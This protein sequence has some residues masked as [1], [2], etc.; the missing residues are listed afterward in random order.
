MALCPRLSLPQSLVRF[1]TYTSSKHY[2][3]NLFQTEY[4]YPRNL[5]HL[6]KAIRQPK[7]PLAL[8]SFLFM[9]D[10]PNQRPPRQLEDFPPFEADIKVYH[11]AVAVFYAPSELCGT[12]GLHRERI[13]SNPSFHGHKRRDT[14]FVVLDDSKNG[15][16]GM[17]I[18]RVLLFF[19]FHY[20]RK[21]FSC[22]LINWFVHDEERDRDTGMWTVQ[23][24]CD[25]TGQPTVQVIELDTIVRGA[26]LLPVYGSSRIPDDFSHHDALDSFDSFFVNHFI[27]QHAHELMTAL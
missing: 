1:S 27:D 18:G 23:L 17:E 20:R 24:E 8:R 19:S 13:R 11:S 2:L 14:V 25:R 3:T 21:D 7:F 4:G 5:A 15:M 10:R 12:G 6:A 26:H 9:Y 16:E 22:A